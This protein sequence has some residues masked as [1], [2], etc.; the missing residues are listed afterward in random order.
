M[1]PQTIFHFAITESTMNDACDYL[2]SNQS[3]GSVLFLA[4]EQTHGMGRNKNRWYSNKGGLWFT[5]CLNQANPPHQISLFIG[6]CLFKVLTTM[7]PRLEPTLTIKWPNDMIYQNKKLSGILVKTCSDYLLIG[8]GINSNNP[9]LSID[10]MFDFISLKHIVGC[11][12]SNSALVRMLIKHITAEMPD[13]INS[14]LKNYL[15][16]INTNLFAYNKYIEFD[17]NGV[18]AF[19]FCKGIE[20]DGSLIIEEPDGHTKSYYS[21]SI[22]RC[23]D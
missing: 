1:H 14:G 17:N 7:F 8:I 10:S 22:V 3:Q 19:G 21:G 16:I 12:V 5:Y 23:I 13:F 20:H 15:S 18:S 6:Y 9:Y 11:N 4:D 2:L